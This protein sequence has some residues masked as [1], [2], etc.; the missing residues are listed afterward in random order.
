MHTTRDDDD[1][2]GTLV[3]IH[4]LGHLTLAVSYYYQLIR[5]TQDPG[6]HERV[7]WRVYKYIRRHGVYGFMLVT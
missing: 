2:D 3:K 7:C 5:G 1:G 6:L 4:L